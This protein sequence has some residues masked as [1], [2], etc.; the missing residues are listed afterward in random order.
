MNI[1]PGICNT[2]IVSKILRNCNSLSCCMN[3]IQHFEAESEQNPSCNMNKIAGL[4][5][6]LSSNIRNCPQDLRFFW[7]CQ[8]LSCSS[9]RRTMNKIPGICSIVP[10]ILQSLE[11]KPF[12][13]FRL[14]L[15]LSLSLS[16]SLS[17][18]LSLSVTAFSTSSTSCCHFLCRQ[19]PLIFK[20]F[21]SIGLVR[22]LRGMGSGI[23][24]RLPLPRVTRN[25]FMKLIGQCLSGV[26]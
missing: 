26:E 25:Y 14:S 24:C 12:A 23:N 2:L 20:G 13:I 17:L 5:T 11:H 15:S 22:P 3:E 4:H 8:S 9:L 1:N 21:S 7:R 6:I 18:R 10:C 16:V 19:G